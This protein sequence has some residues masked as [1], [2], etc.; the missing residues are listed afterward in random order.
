MSDPT[1]WEDQEYQ[2]LKVY[3]VGQ[4]IACNTIQIAEIRNL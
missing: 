1:D 4:P 3:D 2:Q